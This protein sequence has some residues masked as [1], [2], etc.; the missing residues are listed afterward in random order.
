MTSTSSSS[1]EGTLEQVGHHPGEVLVADVG[2]A[3]ERSRIHGKNVRQPYEKVKR[4]THEGPEHVDQRL[5]VRGRGH[6][7]LV[8]G[9]HGSARDDPQIGAGTA[10][11]GEPAGPPAHPHPVREGAARGPWPGDLE[12]DLAA[13]GPPVTDPPGV[14]V[15]IRRS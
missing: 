1:T 6:D 3:E 13:D 11:L 4:R 7:D 9:A 14:D 2:G 5:T 8:T 10:D 12:D 15:E